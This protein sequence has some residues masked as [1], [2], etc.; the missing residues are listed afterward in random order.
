M[1][2]SCAVF[3]NFFRFAGLRCPPIET[4][5]VL[6]IYTYRCKKQTGW[7]GEKSSRVWRLVEEFRYDSSI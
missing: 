4:T 7:I 1:R 3:C 2:Q 5:E 6:S